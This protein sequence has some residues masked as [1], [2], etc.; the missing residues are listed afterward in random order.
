MV[1]NLN[2]DVCWAFPAFYVIENRNVVV[3]RRDGGVQ[4]SN[5]PSHI[6]GFGCSGSLINQATH[7]T[8]IDRSRWLDCVDPLS[9][10]CNL[11]EKNLS[12]NYFHTIFSYPTLILRENNIWRHSRSFGILPI[13][14]TCSF[15][16][17][18]LPNDKDV[19]NEVDVL[20][21]RLT[22]V[23][24]PGPEIE[25]SSRTVLPPG[26]RCIVDVDQF[27]P[28]SRRGDQCVLSDIGLPLCFEIR[29][30]SIERSNRR[31]EDSGSRD[32]VRTSPIVLLGG[33]VLIL[34]GMFCVIEPPSSLSDLTRRVGV[35]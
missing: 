19:W 23:L 32:P 1:L 29:P 5:H 31:E 14:F 2:L 35:R 24:V 25:P 8:E 20:R 18:S 16:G 4:V 10:G 12:T 9:I 6:G 33:A 17:G 28:S 30:I 27:Q 13:F 34:C 15:W 22:K 26:S 7:H 21:R 3:I 11:T